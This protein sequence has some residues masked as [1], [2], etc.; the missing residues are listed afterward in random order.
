VILDSS[1][2]VITANDAFYKTFLIA[3]SDTEGRFIHQICD[4]QWDISYLRTALENLLVAHARVDDF[5]V[6][7]DF[8]H[9]GPKV[10]STSKP[11]L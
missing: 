3:P 8:P 5:E 10:L 1:L 11:I 6:R 2:R 9:I 4:G 7:G